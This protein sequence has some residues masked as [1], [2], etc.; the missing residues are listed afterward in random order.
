MPSAKWTWQAGV[1]F[2]KLTGVRA[3]LRA[4]AHLPLPPRERSLLVQ[5]AR[6][7][8]VHVV[9]D[10]GHHLL[11]G[12]RLWV[13]EQ[14]R[15]G[16][17]RHGA[18]VS[19]P[20]NPCPHSQHC[21]K[22][23]PDGRIVRQQYTSG[24]GAPS[25]REHCRDSSG[26]LCLHARNVRY[27]HAM[28]EVDGMQERIGCDAVNPPGPGRV[29][30]GSSWAWCA[31]GACR[32]PANSAVKHVYRTSVPDAPGIPCNLSTANPAL[33]LSP[34]LMSTRPVESL[35]ATP[36]GAKPNAQAARG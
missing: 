22:E 27:G 14:Q 31:A 17:H 6:G 1:S 10:V 32:S 11:P 5:A 19:Q 24:S 36:G 12:S 26:T 3:T 34:T 13:K 9:Q 20:A 23:G 28:E 29:P 15:A 35:Q 4:A 25:C 33:S 18:Y 21:C 30:P 2:G 16:R 7:V 8:R